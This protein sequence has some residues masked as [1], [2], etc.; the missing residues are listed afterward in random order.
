MKAK[1]IAILIFVFTM[2]FGASV[3]A[4]SLWGSYEGFQKVKVRVNGTELNIGEK[5]T[6]AFS[7]K[8]NAVTPLQQTADSLKAVLQWNEATQTA[9]LYKPNVHMFFA[10]DSAADGSLTKPFAKVDKGSNISFV[11]AVQIDNLTFKPKSFRI[12][13]EDPDGNQVVEPLT[14]PIDKPDESFWFNYL[15][16]VNFSKAGHYTVKFAFENQGAYTVVSE[17]TILSE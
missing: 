9:D 12:T 1:R 7:I 3:Y 6:P 4:D 11:T 15:F 14:M 13:I 2:L 17:K 8:G 10:K 5:D 16:K